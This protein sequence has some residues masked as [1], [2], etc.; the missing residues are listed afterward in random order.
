MTSV[1][2]AVLSGDGEILANFR[3][4][5]AACLSPVEEVLKGL[6]SSG[7]GGVIL[8]G[9]ISEPVCEIPVEPN[10][11]GMVLVG[12]LNPVA[13]AREA[14]IEVE[15]YSMFTLVDYR[16]FIKYTEI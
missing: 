11:V 5:P 14:G 1:R 2:E 3:E 15:N 16:N 8:R 4:V 13:A 10:K 9:G 12:G 7:L 6:K